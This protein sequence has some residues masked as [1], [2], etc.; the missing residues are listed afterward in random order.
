MARYT[1]FSIPVEKS[2][3]VCTYSAI[4]E[5]VPGTILLCTRISIRFVSSVTGMLLSKFLP[6]LVVRLQKSTL[7]PRWMFPGQLVAKCLI[8]ITMIT[9][10]NGC[11]LQYRSLR[12]TLHILGVSIHT[13]CL[14]VTTGNQV[15]MSSEVCIIVDHTSIS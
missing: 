13:S 10:K 3:I 4:W 12:I 5:H 2:Y 6:I 8:Q 14:F 1:Y 15:Q 7:H 9:A 11:Y